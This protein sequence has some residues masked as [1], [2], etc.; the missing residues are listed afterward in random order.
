MTDPAKRPICE[1]TLTALAAH[2]QA[3]D[4]SAWDAPISIAF[5]RT[6]ACCTPFILLLPSRHSNALV[7]STSCEKPVA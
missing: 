3:G 7:S 5:A 4:V 1:L 6:T 2:L